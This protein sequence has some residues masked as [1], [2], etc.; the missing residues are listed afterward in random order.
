MGCVRAG[1]GTSA[2]G[3]SRDI[4][5]R[6]GFG[7]ISGHSRAAVLATDDRAD[8]SLRVGSAGFSRGRV[9]N[10][11]NQPLVSRDAAERREVRVALEP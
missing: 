6:A 11:L 2:L 7:G 3:L 4:G 5:N 8:L 9:L 10:E 1:P